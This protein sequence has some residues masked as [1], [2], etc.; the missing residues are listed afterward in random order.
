MHVRRHTH[1]HPC[2]ALQVPQE[3]TSCVRTCAP[4]ERDCQVGS[5]CAVAP[6]QVF[7]FELIF[8]FNFDSTSKQVGEQVEILMNAS[9]RLDQHGNV[10]GVI[11]IGQALCADFDLCVPCTLVARASAHN[12]T[13][14]NVMQ[15][16]VHRTSQIY[17]VLRRR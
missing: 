3:G 7:I 10:T 14:C 9:C 16:N 8:I 1:T 2:T 13:Q 5:A 17:G 11:G 4:W 15:P 12:T 6:G